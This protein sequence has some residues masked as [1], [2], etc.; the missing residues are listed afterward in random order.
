MVMHARALDA[1]LC[2]K[3]AKAEAPY[4]ALRIWAS[5]RSINRSAVSL[6][7]ESPLYRSIGLDDPSHQGYL[8]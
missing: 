5:A 8:S 1:D 6:T 7:V 4:P 2:R 3:V